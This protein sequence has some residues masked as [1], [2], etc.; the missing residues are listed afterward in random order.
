MALREVQPRQHESID[1]DEAGHSG[2]AD[3]IYERILAAI[4]ERRLRPGTRL[5]EEK[6]ARIFSVSRT[7]IRETLARLA[8][9]GTV[10]LMANRGALVSS[11]PVKQAREVF[12]ARRVIEPALV[13][14]LA[15]G[16]DRAVLERL[17]A[18]VTAEAKA[19]QANDRQRI[20]RLSGEFHMLIAEMA[21]NGFLARTM[22]ELTSLTCLIIALYDSPTVPACPCDE[23]GD[24]TDA[25]A[26]GDPA[27]AARKMFEHLEHVENALDLELVEGDE[28]SLEAVF[29]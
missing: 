3:G 28:V 8:H 1:H 19:R 23:H 4:L 11:P 13:Q 21:D 6:L 27:G 17:R 20:I 29:M 12:E 22:R 26:A 15:T 10:T 14:G 25:I 16:S 9:E 24:I 2:T 7:K 5:P 18:H